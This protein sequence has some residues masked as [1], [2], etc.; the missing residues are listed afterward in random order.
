MDLD[1]DEDTSPTF[2]PASRS[3]RTPSGIS[4]TPENS[5]PYGSRCNDTHTQVLKLQR[6]IALLADKIGQLQDSPAAARQV[7]NASSRHRN[8]PRDMVVSITAITIYPCHV[9]PLTGAGQRNL[10]TFD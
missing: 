2:P 7:T 9:D 1:M 6:Q 8:L 3:I 10:S 4:S 5:T